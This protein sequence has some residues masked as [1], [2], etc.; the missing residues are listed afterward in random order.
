VSGER[1]AGAIRELVEQV[2][3]LAAPEA[4]LA[5]AAGAVHA[6]TERLRASGT[7]RPTS[8]RG[9]M[10]PGEYLRLNPV[11][12]V[13]NPHAPP[14]TY[15][16]GAEGAVEAA[17]AFG[18][19]YQGPPG[20]VHGAFI[21]GVFDDVLGAVNL[22]SGHPGMTVRLEVRYRRA[23]P[24]HTPLRVVARHTGREGR[25]I[26]ASATMLAGDEVTAEAEGVFAEIT[27]DRAV[28]LFG[29]ER[30]GGGMADDAA[31]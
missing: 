6:A 20:Y 23:T 28:A 27:V 26:F 16:V 30:F 10:H 7:P 21:A 19:A 25:R 8:F 18:A 15:S 31:L 29:R 14:A 5:E 22:A 13:L 12:G 3:A 1:L 24:L 17:V 11:S 2:A 9:G 4:A